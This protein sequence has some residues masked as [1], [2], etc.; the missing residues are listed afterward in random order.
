MHFSARVPAPQGMDET[1]GFPRAN[2][3]LSF[4]LQLTRSSPL[5][6]HRTTENLPDK[7]DVTI[8]G[9]G[10]SG[11]ATAYFLLTTGPEDKR[12]KSVLLLEARDACD[13]ATAR[14]G[15]HCRP[16]CYRDYRQYKAD[17][18]REQGLKI[19]QNEKDTLN[20]TE[21]IIAKE[22]IDCDFWR[23]PSYGMSFLIS[24]PYVAMDQ[25]VADA[26]AASYAEFAA[27]GGP[28]EGVVIP[29]IDPAQARAETRCPGATAAYT[30]ASSG[31]LFPRKLVLHL[32]ALCIEK[33]GMNLQTHTPVRRVVPSTDEGV[34]GWRVE[35]DRGVVETQKVVY[36]TN[37]FTATLL[38]EFLGHIYPFRG[39]CSAVVPPMAYA[40]KNVLPGTYA[41]A[42][43]DY[44]LSRPGIFADY[45]IQ[46]PDGIIIFGGQRAAVPAEDL[47]D[48][49]D[50]TVVDPR[51]TTGLRGGAA[52][53]LCWMAQGGGRGSIPY[54]GELHDKPGAFICAGHH[55]HGMAR[56]MSCAKGLA[57][58]IQG[59]SWEST[60]LPECFEPTHERLA[61]PAHRTVYTVV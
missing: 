33:H 29:I 10:L 57:A 22:G 49:T 52:S 37:A 15:G 2:P 6:G 27:D 58:L 48:N 55:G 47:R 34:G 50:D 56:I 46:R 11:A 3:C 17:F 7:A 35:T 39:Q 23:G 53:A 30:S 16:D 8:I 61:R 44:H 51:M 24:F 38:P 1:P 5:H 43:E 18:G 14:N 4:W 36:A 41:M 28:V 26:L 54:V 20:L 45:L 59:D 19:I 32:L 42:Y 13:G 31:S 9:S 12:P 60:G 25:S 40:G 21:E